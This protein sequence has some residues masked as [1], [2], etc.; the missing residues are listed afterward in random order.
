MPPSVFWFTRFISTT[1]VDA[2]DVYGSRFAPFRTWTVVTLV[3]AAVLAAMCAGMALGSCSQLTAALPRGHVLPAAVAVMLVPDQHV[4]Y[5]A[6]PNAYP[7]PVAARSGTVTTDSSALA[8]RFSTDPQLP[9][10][11][12]PAP[13]WLGSQLTFFPRCLVG[14]TFTA[15][16]SPVTG[17]TFHYSCRSVAGFVSSRFGCWRLGLLLRLLLI[18]SPQLLCGCCYCWFHCLLVVIIFIPQFVI[19]LIWVDWT[20][21]RFGYVVYVPVGLLDYH[22]F[23]PDGPGCIYCD[24]FAAFTHNF[25]VVYVLLRFT[26]LLDTFVR[27]PRLRWTHATRLQCLR[28]LVYGCLPHVTDTVP[29]V[30]IWTAHWTVDL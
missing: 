4:G 28:C 19:Y 30:T 14:P 17:Y 13:D 2:N 3:R 6:C 29:L 22:I 24:L 23:I 11:W 18:D 10:S 12:F 9:H 20:G 25:T 1:P 26:R 27:L 21:G 16:A 15:I 5:A 7:G 8:A